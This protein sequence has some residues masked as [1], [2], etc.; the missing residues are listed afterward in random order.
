MSIRSYHSFADTERIYEEVTRQ[1]ATSFGRTYTEETRF[2]LMGTTDQRSA[3]IAIDEC[4]LPLSVK[5]YLQR[6][7]KMCSERMSTVPVLKG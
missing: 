5:E 4:R 7:H 1:I 6:Y 2:R 3:E